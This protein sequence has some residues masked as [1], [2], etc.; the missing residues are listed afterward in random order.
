[1]L[2]PSDSQARNLLAQSAFLAETVRRTCSGKDQ[3]GRPLPHL[4]RGDSTWKVRNP[5]ICVLAAKDETF[6][7]KPSEG[8]ARE[9]V[10]TTT[11]WCQLSA[12]SRAICTRDSKPSDCNARITLSAATA[13]RTFS[14]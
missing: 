12:Q 11:F 6:P 1:V 13:W 5:P 7:V 3:Y 14:G 8:D 2:E 9:S 4:F 10:T